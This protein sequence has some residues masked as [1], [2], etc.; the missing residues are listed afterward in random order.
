MKRSRLMGGVLAVL[1]LTAGAMAWAVWGRERAPIRVGLLHSRTG[2]WASVERS[3]LE[4]EVL[5]I[6]E[7]NAAGGVLGRP[8]VAVEADGRSDPATFA[9][10]AHHLIRN[11]K[12]SVLIGCWSSEARRAVRPVVEEEGHLL[13][14]PPSFEG[15]EESPNIVYTGGPANQQVGPAV[16]WC[17]EA[18]KARKFFLVGSDSFW[19]RVVNAVARDQIRALG[20]ETVG[21]EYLGAGESPPLLADHV[22]RIQRAAPDVVLSTVEGQDAGPFYAQLRRA[23]IKPDRTPVVSYSLD[24]ELVRRLPIADVV[25]QYASWN[26]FQSI[27]RPENREFVARFRAKYGPDRVV[28]DNIQ[29]AYQSVYFWS[30]A[31]AEAGTDEVS[32][33]NQAVPRQSRN[34]PEGI[35]SIDPE[36]RQGW[37]TFF[38]GKVRTDGQFDVV[39]SMTRPIRPVPFPASRTRQE[40]DALVDER[41]PKE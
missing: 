22:G 3:M 31:V 14:Y 40:W 13:I 11:E 25:G 17:H 2:P 10:Q 4:A 18:L 30:Q 27:D 16:S 34:A 9:R 23:G 36:N 12:V 5:A 7:I 21:E 6:E 39:T 33:V 24:E 32:T 29:I 37:R 38:L 20:G 41:G 15:L 1:C 8:L 26:Y 28:D 35:V 19:A